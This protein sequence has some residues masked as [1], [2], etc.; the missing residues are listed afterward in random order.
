MSAKHSQ[1]YAEHE[2]LGRNCRFLQAPDGKVEPGSFRR[3]CDNSVI[4]SIKESIKRREECQ[5]TAINYK[6]TGEPFINLMTLI[7]LEYDKPGETA[8]YIGLQVDL[9]DQPKSILNRMKVDNLADFNE[10]VTDL[11]AP[12]HSPNPRDITPELPGVM[13]NFLET[14]SDFVHILSLRGLF[15]YAA[16]SATQRLLEYCAEDLMGHPLSEFVHPAD[17]VAVM[18]ELRSATPEDSINIMCRFRRKHS[19]YMYMEITGHMYEGEV[20]KRTKC[21]VLTGRERKV[22]TL[23]IKDVLLPKRQSAETWAKLSPQGL[24]LFICPNSGEL[25]GNHQDDMYAHSILEFVSESD[26]QAIQNALRRVATER[27]VQNVRCQILNKRN[28]VPVLFRLYND[29]DSMARTIICQIRLL[30]GSD[31]DEPVT[32]REYEELF[33]A[34][35]LFDVMGEVRVTSLHYELNQLRIHNKRLRGE[36]ETLTAPPKKKSVSL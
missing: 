19:G 7:P 30:E 34:G 3:Y 27:I 5:Y 32:L 25:F 2:L 12:A 24:I 1:S 10:E 35:N 18:R 36:L 20:G 16:P 22:P 17:L 11:I 13:H 29:G 23:P 33:D 9:V 28:H 6:K 15:L 14:Y 4:H 21:F 26:H 31:A 8:F